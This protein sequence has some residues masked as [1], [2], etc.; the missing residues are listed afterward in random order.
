MELVVSASRYQ[1][2]MLRKVSYWSSVRP[3]C[4]EPWLRMPHGGEVSDSIRKSTLANCLCPPIQINWVFYGFRSRR[5]E[6]I[7]LQRA[8][9]AEHIS[10]TETTASAVLQ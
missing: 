9:M 2:D 8:S 6:A 4:H 7:H 3:N 10:P 5:F 1:I